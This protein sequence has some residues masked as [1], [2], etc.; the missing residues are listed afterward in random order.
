MTNMQP[1]RIKTIRDYHQI[2]KL[3][4]SEHPLISVVNF[5][6]IRQLPDKKPLSIVFDFYSISL[7]KNFNAKMKYGQQKYDFDEG[8]M[9]FISPGKVFGVEVE[10]GKELTHTG[11]LLLV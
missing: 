8:T 6:S 1:Y 3:P 4:K 10:V 7:K 9:S 2:M 11:W 5:E